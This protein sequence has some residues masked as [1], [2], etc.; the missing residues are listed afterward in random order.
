V[1]PSFKAFVY[2]MQMDCLMHRLVRYISFFES[3]RIYA[4]NGSVNGRA[5]RFVWN[6]SANVLWMHAD[7]G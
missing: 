5:L 4:H 7:I 2:A 6:T 1:L 3:L